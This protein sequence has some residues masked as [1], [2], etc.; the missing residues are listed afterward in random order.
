MG[1]HRKKTG[2]TQENLYG[3]KREPLQKDLEIVSLEEVPLETRRK[4]A[5]KPLFLIRYE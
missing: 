4:E 5:N 1:D 2:L 3:T